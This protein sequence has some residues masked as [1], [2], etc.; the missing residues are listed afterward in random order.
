MLVQK[1][2]IAALL[3]VC[4]VVFAPILIFLGGIFTSKTASVASNAT[5]GGYDA[6]ADVTEARIEELLAEHSVVFV[7]SDEVDPISPMSI[8]NVNATVPAYDYYFNGS[9]GVI[10]GTVYKSAHDT[11]ATLAALKK[12]IVEDVESGVALTGYDSTDIYRG[13]FNV[14]D[15]LI[16]I[17][18]KIVISQVNAAYKGELMGV[19]TTYE[20]A[21][22]MNNPTNEVGMWVVITRET[23]LSP[24]QTKNRNYKG[25][26]VQHVLDASPEPIVRDYAPLA[27]VPTSTFS[28]TLNFGSSSKTEEG[29]LSFSYTTPVKSPKVLVPGGIP[30]KSDIK[31]EYIDPG[32]WYGSYCEY[33]SSESKQC[34]M[35][36]LELSKSDAE[37]KYSTSVTGRFQKYENWPFPWL[38]EYFTVE[39][40]YDFAVSDLLQIIADANA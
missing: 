11:D 8:S 39:R 15:T 26:G 22:V 38:D 35:V 13:A 17:Y 3:G 27:H 34:S 36:V 20:N 19:M 23:F 12:S 14:A 16:S 18:D 30:Y 32:S 24:K 5:S 31:F 7:E 37:L 9:D 25:V 40:S 2:R 10:N 28:Y 21:F 6:P 29:G 33:N 4:V 1:K